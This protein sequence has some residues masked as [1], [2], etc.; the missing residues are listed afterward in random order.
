MWRIS[1]LIQRILNNEE[2]IATCIV[3]GIILFVSSFIHKRRFGLLGLA[4]AAG[5]ILSGIWGF[6][7][8]LIASALKIPDNTLSSAAILSIIV[9]LPAGILLFHGSTYKSIIGRVVGASLFTI[10]ALA[11][12]FEPLSHAM[13]PT[14]AG[15]VVYNWFTDNKSVI[16]GLGLIAAVVDLF[17]TKPAHSHHKDSKH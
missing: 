4:L 9:L 12:L 10:L 14:D 6:D 1:R 7:A 15:L 11:F 8:Q 13:A 16:I 2:V 3:I 17:L 5:S